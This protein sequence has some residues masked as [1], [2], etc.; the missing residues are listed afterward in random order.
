MLKILTH[1]DFRICILLFFVGAL[2]KYDVTIIARLPVGELLAFAS[3]PFLIHG[4]LIQ[5]YKR[6]VMYFVGLFLIWSLGIVLSDLLNEFV[7]LRFIRGLMKPL[8]S[9]LWML[10]FIGVLSRRRAPQAFMFYI[11]GGL[12]AAVQNWLMP[13]SFEAE[14]MATGGY[15]ALAF[16]IGPAIASLN[17]VI[18]NLLYGYHP[19]L[20]AVSYFMSAVVK[21]VMGSPRSGIA[22][23][24]LVV[25]FICYLWWRVRI[26]KRPIRLSLGRLIPASMLLGVLCLAI[27]YT[28]VFIAGQGW[29]GEL[30]HAK[31]LAQQ[32]TIFGTNPLG[33]L[34][35]GRTAVF[36][37]ILAIIDNPLLGYGSWTAWMMTDYYYEA[38]S[39][40]GTN[41]GKLR[42]IMNAD[43]A[44]IGHSV[45]FQ[46]WVENGILAATALLVVGWTSLKQFIRLM[47]SN[48]PYAPYFIALFISF[49]WSYFFSPFGTGTRFM[50]GLI[51]AIN[52]TDFF[53]KREWR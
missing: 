8:F 9:C 18:A 20:A 43:Y 32:Q 14:Y 47:E 31:L 39:L 6:P 5:R 34:L 53:G 3:I 26:L 21:V 46:G 23:Q 40:V 17:S 10:F 27:Y 16:G 36:G 29:M 30:Q 44:G 50:I 24:L 38:V 13:T 52:A 28:Y 11:V 45:L 19:L 12:F 25:S 49:C 1:R 51:C 35:D 42:M 37:A 4:G 15:E 22:M 41:S 33:L 7:F 48:V 2:R